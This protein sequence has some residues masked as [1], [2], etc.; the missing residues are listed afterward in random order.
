MA[1][2]VLYSIIEFIS[3]SA[4]GGSNGDDHY[5]VRLFCMRTKP[6]TPDRI[7]AF[8]VTVA[9]N[10]TPPV[11]P[12]SAVGNDTK[13]GS[14]SSFLRRSD[15]PHL[16]Q[17]PILEDEQ[18]VVDSLWATNLIYSKLQTKRLVDCNLGL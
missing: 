3:S 7:G 14:P 17:S 1:N 12:S 5:P 2:D 13:R 18:P 11:Q 16:R 6:L 4:V 15:A 9:I 10:I 8:E